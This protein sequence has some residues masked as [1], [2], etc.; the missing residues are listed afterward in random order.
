MNEKGCITDQALAEHVFECFAQKINVKSVTLSWYKLDI[1]ARRA[2]VF[3][4]V[5]GLPD[6]FLEQNGIRAHAYI[7]PRLSYIF[8]YV[9]QKLSP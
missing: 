8:E 6:E 9:L 1:Y 5:E 7:Y 4:I 2:L 3:G